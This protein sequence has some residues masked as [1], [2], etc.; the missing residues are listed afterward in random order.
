[1]D[2]EKE[3]NEALERAMT[4]IKECGD[5]EGRKRMIYSI[6]PQL[7]ECEEET[8]SAM[9]LIAEER[10]KQISKGF[11]WRHDDK[12]DCHQLSDAAIVYAAP[13]PLRYQ[14]MNWWPWDKKSLKE[15]DSFT[16]EGRIGELVKA[17]ALIV[18]EIERLQR[19]V[20]N[21]SKPIEGEDE[22]IR[23]ALL[24]KFVGEKNQGAKYTIHGCSL[25]NII[26]YLKKQKEENHDG[27]KWIYEDEA[28]ESARIIKDV[29]FLVAYEN[30][31]VEYDNRLRMAQEAQ[32]RQ[33]ID[34]TEM[35]EDLK[36]KINDTKTRLT[37][38]RQTE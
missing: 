30:E 14:V 23:Q 10:E 38:L 27:K 35:I 26:T 36:K 37:E 28:E 24:T 5:N 32:D 25:D 34:L 21:V 31:L 29:F 16:T 15:D 6:F 20:N 18:A 2:Y 13:A 17:G 22:R 19:T 8:K 4:Q 1:M 7:C 12:H 33:Q 9:D 11:N 3:Y